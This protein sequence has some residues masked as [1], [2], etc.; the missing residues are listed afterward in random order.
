MT[1]AVLA[2][3]AFWAA[4]LS[5]GFTA[6]SDC[7]EAFL[8]L[9]TCKVELIAYYDCPSNVVEA[10]LQIRSYETR[11]EQFSACHS[12]ASWYSKGLCN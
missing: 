10:S 4:P 3:G 1:L 6:L 5:V 9:S 8:R 7:H 2:S 12:I 11:V